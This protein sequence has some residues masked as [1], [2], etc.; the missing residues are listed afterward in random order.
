MGQKW[1]TSI[2]G[3]LAIKPGQLLDPAGTKLVRDIRAT[4][5][6]EKMKWARPLTMAI[7]VKN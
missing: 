4:E 5:A 3:T 7:S 1:E 6:V 2:E